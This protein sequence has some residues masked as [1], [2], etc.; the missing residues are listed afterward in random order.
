MVFQ[1]YALYPNMSVFDNMAFG[2]KIRKTYSNTEIKKRV[3]GSYQNL[4]T[5]GPTEVVDGKLTV[6]GQP[7]LIKYATN[8]AV[9]KVADQSN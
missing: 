5:D 3:D 8:T 1:T 4:L 9:T 2:L 6:D 7:V